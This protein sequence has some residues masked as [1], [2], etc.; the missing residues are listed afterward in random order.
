MGVVRDTKTGRPRFVPNEDLQPLLDTGEVELYP[1]Q[2]VPVVL[3]SGKVGTG[4]IEA[5]TPSLPLA[6]EEAAREADYE[7]RFGGSTGRAIAEGLARGATFAASDVI[8][9]AAGA[10][11]RGLRERR[12]RG[13]APVTAA[14]ITGSLVLPGLGAAQIAKGGLKAAAV[15]GGLEGVAQ[16]TGEAVSDLTLSADPLTTEKI[17]G[18][19]PLRVLL[20]GVGGAAGGVLVKSAARGLRRGREMVREARAKQPGV[21]GPGVEDLAGHSRES[22]KELRDLETA[23]LA[24]NR[25]VQE[26]EIADEVIAHHQTS[27]SENVLPD[28]EPLRVAARAQDAAQQAEEAALKLEAQVTEKAS[29]AQDLHTYQELNKSA[30][31]WLAI[32]K[33]HAVKYARD[34][35]NLTFKA[36]RRL[37]TALGNRIGL[38]KDPHRALEALQ[39]Q[40]TA[41]QRLVDL[42]PE[43]QRRLTA[44][45]R[46]G[47]QRWSTLETV[48]DL[49]QRNREL[50]QRL[51]DVYRPVV[52]GESVESAAQRM[53]I[54]EA[55]GIVANATKAGRTAG[56]NLDLTVGNPKGLAENPGKVLADLRVQEDALVRLQEQLPLAQRRLA[57]AGGAPLNVGGDLEA[58]LTRNRALQQRLASIKDTPTSARL[59]AINEAIQ[60][61]LERKGI[62]TQV[63][64][65]LAGAATM[66]AVGPFA[67][68]A[69]AGVAGAAVA[70][71]VG[72][73]VTRRLNRVATATSGRYA[74]AVEK[75]LALTER[76][77][78]KAPVLASKV[79][80]HYAPD[81]DDTGDMH[82]TYKKWEK[83]LRST[84]TIDPNTGQYLATPAAKR[85]VYDTLEGLRA[86]NIQA[87]DML[88]TLAARKMSYL[89]SKLPK[90]PGHALR[91]LGPDTWRPADMAIREFARAVAAVEDPP[92]ILERVA[93]GTVT[94]EDK[95]A[96]QTVYPETYAALRIQVAERLSMLQHN[97]PMKRRMALSL[98]FD[99]P[100]EPSMDPAVL[101]VL[102]GNFAAE[103]GTEGG[104]V[105]PQALPAFGSIRNQEPTAS[106]ERAGAQ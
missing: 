41:F 103:P 90:R 63:V 88:E 32:E 2:Q 79:L 91:Q 98:T 16:G 20:G 9:T 53:A 29:I 77:A 82:T 73:V 56:K 3:P 5:V 18:A 40:D 27:K 23:Q 33:D 66:A 51:A 47:G 22:L 97:L 106:Q 75:I 58:Q 72:Q 44:E 86:Q 80:A 54:D 28:F 25:V 89:A 95:E 67:G 87:A 30:K 4:P 96:L 12:A 92:G 68:F 45:G 48:P 84:T 34:T 94:P 11:R 59:E 74:A 49:L 10:S 93:D 26:R 17:A 19:L 8:L 76:A 83:H 43:L 39:R 101:R 21:V 99:L 81:G 64:Q 78:G 65:G 55:E 104:T 15:Y 100:V 6:S 36:D 31:P 24:T 42:T 7:Q 37:D 14:E 105:A 57:D 102:Q 70:A 71:G 52:V 50:Q 69:V 38:A 60:V 61:P 46:V 1:G 35:K 13:G 85:Q 62:G